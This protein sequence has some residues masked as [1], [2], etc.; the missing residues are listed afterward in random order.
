MTALHGHS[1]HTLYRVCPDCK[2]SGRGSYNI[3]TWCEK[4]RRYEH[5]YYPKCEHCGGE[6]FVVTATKAST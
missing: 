6:K 2:G 4:C 1:E 3:G 5:G